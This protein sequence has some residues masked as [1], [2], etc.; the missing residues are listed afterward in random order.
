MIQPG[1]LVT[2][3]WKG[4]FRVIS[5]R[6]KCE[7]NPH[8]VLQNW[9]YE[10]DPTAGKIIGFEVT[11]IQEFDAKGNKRSSKKPVTCD[12]SYCKLAKD[13]LPKVITDLDRTKNNLLSILNTL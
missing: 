2:G 13:Y 4:Y 12:G 1:D 3:Y 5:V 7:P 9:V 11:M 10:G 6:N 8:K